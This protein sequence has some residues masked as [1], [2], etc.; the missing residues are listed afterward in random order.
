MNAV[1]ESL[2]QVADLGGPVVLILLAVSVITLATVLYKLW[3]FSAAGVGRHKA[4][5][6]AVERTR[7]WQM[8]FEEL[9]K[10][11]ETLPDA[12]HHPDP[13]NLEALRSVIAAHAKQ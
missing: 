9:R 10:A 5:K 13:E 1:L 8:S 2:R 6:E 3:Q 7:W 11:R 4:M 12:I